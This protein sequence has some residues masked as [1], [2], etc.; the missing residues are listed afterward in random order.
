MQ[1]HSRWHRKVILYSMSA[2]I[3][4]VQYIN[5]GLIAS[6]K[7]SSHASQKRKSQQSRKEQQNNPAKNSTIT[8]NLSTVIGEEFE[9][10]A[11]TLTYK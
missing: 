9:N 6:P 10:V 3:Q 2:G 1:E 8:G 7:H 4:H 5:P 11:L